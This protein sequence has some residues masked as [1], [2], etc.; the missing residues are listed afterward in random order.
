[1][2]TVFFKISDQ[3]EKELSALMEE[4]GYT[5]K[6]EFFRFLLK[7]F[8]YTRSPEDVKFENSAREL[9]AILRELDKK[10]KLSRSLKDQIADL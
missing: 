7:F 5:N 6:S 9:T 8:K 2:A 10:G 1:M 3:Q 4:E